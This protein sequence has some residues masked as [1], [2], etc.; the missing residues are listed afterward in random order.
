MGFKQAKKAVPR[1][2]QCRPPLYNYIQSP[3]L[4]KVSDLHLN[5]HRMSYYT[6][7]MIAIGYFFESSQDELGQIFNRINSIGRII[8]LNAKHGRRMQIVSES[9][10]ESTGFQSSDFGSNASIPST[11]SSKRRQTVEQ[12]YRINM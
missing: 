10:Q 9:I 12:V 7:E 11:S 4:Q 2:E 8:G 5:T 3:L 1:L 6:F